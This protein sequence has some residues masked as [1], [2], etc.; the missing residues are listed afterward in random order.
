MYIFPWFSWPACCRNRNLDVPRMF[1]FVCKTQSSRLPHI[2]EHIYAPPEVTVR[3]TRR[4]RFMESRKLV[5]T[6]PPPPAQR[7]QSA[8]Q[9]WVMGPLLP[10]HGL[11]EQPRAAGSKTD[12]LTPI[13]IFNLFLFFL[14][15]ARASC[16][17]TNAEFRFRPTGYAG[18][19]L[20]QW[21]IYVMT[22]SLRC[23]LCQV[24]ELENTLCDCVAIIS[25]A[26]RFCFDVAAAAAALG[27]RGPRAKRVF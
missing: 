14:S 5:P 19:S 17:L 13:M 4:A 24:A 12:D 21:S 8:L 9:P 27:V 18:A 20:L 16:Q 22:P 15:L 10:L 6:V 11:V 23:R 26:Q 7:S 3:F 1:F 2:S 25:S